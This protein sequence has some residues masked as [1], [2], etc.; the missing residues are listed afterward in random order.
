MVN[1]DQIRNSQ[2]E[3]EPIPPSAFWRLLF[4]GGEIVLT[5]GGAHANSNPKKDV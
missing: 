4:L 3:I 1:H 2:F 5:P